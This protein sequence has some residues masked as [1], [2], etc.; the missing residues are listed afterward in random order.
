MQGFLYA[1]KPFQASPKA[2]FQRTGLSA[3]ASRL[4]LET[5]SRY[6]SAPRC[7][8]E[9]ADKNAMLKAFLLSAPSLSAS[10]FKKTLEK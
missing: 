10:L 6:P 1:E 3:W 5:F 2:C 4:A 8:Q 9:L 7:S